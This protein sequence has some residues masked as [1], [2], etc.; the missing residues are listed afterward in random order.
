MP[1]VWDDVKEI[2]SNTLWNRKG[3]AVGD[4]VEPEISQGMIR[5]T[6][7]GVR[8]RGKFVPGWGTELWTS[9][10]LAVRTL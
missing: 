6:D 1:V 3:N 4:I 10:T 5:V 7:L 8:Y 2:Q 9:I